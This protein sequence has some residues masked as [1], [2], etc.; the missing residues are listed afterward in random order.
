MNPTDPV[1]THPD[2]TH[3]GI[4][5]RTYIATQC[6]ANITSSC[7]H[8]TCSSDVTSN[9]AKVAIQYADALIDELQKGKE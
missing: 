2:Y 4:D 8:F 6:L 1:Y 3:K 9:A 5:L 7:L